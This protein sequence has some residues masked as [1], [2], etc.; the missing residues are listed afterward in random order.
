MKIQMLGLC[1]F[2]LLSEGGFKVVHET[3]D[4]RR[5]LLYDPDRLAQRFLW[6]E[7]VA[8]PSWARQTDPDFK[9]VIAVGEDFPL[10]W[11]ERLHDLVSPIPQIVIEL[12]PPNHH[13]QVCRTAM[14]RHAD[15]SAD[16]M[17]LFRHD[18]DDAVAIDYVESSRRDLQRLGGMADTYPLFYLDYPRGFTLDYDGQVLTLNPQITHTLGVALNIV[19]P[20][21]HDRGA[22]DYP[23]H[24]LI[25]LMPG[26]SLSDPI[27]YLRG[28]HETNDS[29][30]PARGGAPF[31]FDQ[32]HETRMLARRFG[33]DLPAFRSA[34]GLC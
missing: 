10:P 2:S 26:V 25:T 16:R 5:R 32:T 20:A 23:H 17:V 33:I 8:L 29:R 14:L 21:G 7:Y 18:D 9:L 19:A 30:P 31:A 34:L 6:F 12:C 28:K 11:L 15:P 27:M 4:E 24:K 1:R 13:R 3:L 22:L